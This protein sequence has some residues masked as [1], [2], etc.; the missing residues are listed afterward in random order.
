MVFFGGDEA[1]EPQPKNYLLPRCDVVTDRQHNI[2][3][4]SHTFSFPA[5]SSAP[6]N[7]EGHAQKNSWR[8]FSG[9]IK[10]LKKFLE[11]HLQGV[12]TLQLLTECGV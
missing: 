2:S 8:T 4:V 5:S 6:G 11:H 10:I 9:Q 1:H 3:T 7:H 12:G